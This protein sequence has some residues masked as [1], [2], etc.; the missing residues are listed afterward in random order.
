MGI[1]VERAGFRALLTGD[2]EVGE[3]NAW[4]KADV[5]PTVDVLKAAHHGSRNGVTPLWLQT[6]KPKVVVISVGAGNDYGH[7]EPM[8]LRYYE[9]GGRAVYRTDHHGDVVIRVLP[10]GAYKVET[11]KKTPPSSP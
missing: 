6:T 4:L 3:I 8:A 5:I 9:A 1:V 7:P 10:D 2:S 11:E